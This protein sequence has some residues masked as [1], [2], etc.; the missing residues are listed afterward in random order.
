MSLGISN[1]C[2]IGGI[3]VIDVAAESMGVAVGV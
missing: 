2:I 1:V 3:L